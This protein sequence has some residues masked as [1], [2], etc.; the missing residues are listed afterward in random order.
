V[1]KRRST[2]DEA[3]PTV[4]TASPGGKGRPTP[5][6]KTAEAA[7]AAR[8]KPPKDSREARKADRQRAVAERAAARKGLAAGDPKFLPASHRGP[9][10]LWIRNLVDSRWSP[11]ELVL[12]GAFIA[13]LIGLK[14]P[15]ALYFFYFLLLGVVFDS[16]VLARRI[17]HGVKTNF[18]DEPLNGLRMYGVLRAS[19]IRRMRVPKPVVPRRVFGRK[20]KDA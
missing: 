10:R 1:F 18:P 11:G 3:G 12:P 14:T 17:S 2:I 8:V 6:R 15:Y 9:A 20:P 13:F 4:E 7:R 19:L 16:V 5:S